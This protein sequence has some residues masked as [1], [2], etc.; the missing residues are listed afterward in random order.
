MTSPPK[1]IQAS[2]PSRSGMNWKTGDSQCKNCL[3]SVEESDVDICW[4]I[5]FDI[6]V[7]FWLMSRLFKIQENLYLVHLYLPVTIH[8]VKYVQFELR[9]LKYVSFFI[10]FW[11]SSVDDLW[12]INIIRGDCIWHKNIISNFCSS[13]LDSCTKTLKLQK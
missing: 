6:A 8:T 11:C 2:T 3:L 5:T 7:V 12:I 13:D 9:S 1:P 10:F 4:F